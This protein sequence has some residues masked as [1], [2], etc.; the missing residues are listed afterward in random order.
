[1]KIIIDEAN[2]KIARNLIDSVP[3]RN[4]IPYLEKQHEGLLFAMIPKEG[5][6]I[7]DLVSPFMVPVD[8][9]DP[10]ISSPE[11]PPDKQIEYMTKLLDNG[12]VSV[13]VPDGHKTHMHPRFKDHAKEMSEYDTEVWYEVIMLPPIYWVQPA[14]R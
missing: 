13:I 8:A 14:N 9:E 7:E 3:L 1:M 10:N 6:K 4:I 2:K 12:I 5:Y 11:L